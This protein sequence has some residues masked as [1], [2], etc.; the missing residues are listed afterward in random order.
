MF[1]SLTNLSDYPESPCRQYE[2][3]RVSLQFIVLVLII[4]E[5]EKPKSFY[6]ERGIQFFQ[7]M[8]TNKP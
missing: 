5:I 6:P 1:W 3:G 8:V 7:G 2:L 4:I